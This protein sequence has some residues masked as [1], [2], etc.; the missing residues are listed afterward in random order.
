[1]LLVL[2]VPSLSHTCNDLQK[3][4]YLYR[5]AAAAGAAAAMNAESRG[6]QE[7]LLPD[8]RSKRPKTKSN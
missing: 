7:R 8:N 2:F 1:V 3:T 6:I 4:N 5:S